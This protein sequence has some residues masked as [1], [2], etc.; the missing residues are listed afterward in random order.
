MT[1][2][3]LINLAAET[4]KCEG[5]RAAGR[6]IYHDGPTGWWVV[7]DEDMV[8]L[9]RLLSDW[10]S[11]SHAMET[12]CVKSDAVE[13]DIDRIVRDSKITAATDLD[14]LMHEAGA[15]GDTVTYL[16]LRFARQDVVD[17]IR[18]NAEIDRDNEW[19]SDGPLVTGADVELAGVTADHA[20]KW[21]DAHG[22]GSSFV[23]GD[24]ADAIARYINGQTVA[25]AGRKTGRHILVEMRGKR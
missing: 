5:Q 9:G 4:L 6:W 2:E 17:T 21:R 13:I 11:L 24:D 18:I 25:Y 7:E 15:A 22:I 8:T 20:A 3:D 16:V 14:A 19:R 1:R 12:W 23:C 10:V